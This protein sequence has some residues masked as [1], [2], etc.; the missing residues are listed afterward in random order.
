MGH[1]ILH[2]QLVNY[3][4]IFVYFAFVLIVGIALK[5]KMKTGTDFFLSG[6]SIPGWITSLAFLSANLG[7]L[8]M[9]GM[10]A[11]GY[12]YGIMT[13]HY[14]I[15]GAIPAMVFLGF[16]MMPFYYGSKVRSVPEY[17]KF[18]YN[19]ATRGFNAIS[20][21]VMTGPDFQNQIAV[22]LFTKPKV[23]ASV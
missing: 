4:I 17:L 2:P 9:L 12:Q 14:Y 8:E 15:I 5:G 16:F 18:R 22:S 11:S 7:A 20:F 10:V 19:E 21:A 3:L 13:V 23:P 1:A 6:R